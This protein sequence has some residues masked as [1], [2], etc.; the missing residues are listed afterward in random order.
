MVDPERFGNL[1]KP[2]EDLHKKRTPEQQRVLYDKFKHTNTSLL[3]EAIDHLA[4]TAKGFPTPGDIKQAI[5]EVSSKRAKEGRSSTQ[6]KGCPNCHNGVVF[7]EVPNRN[8][9]KIYAGSCAYCHKGEVTIVPF[10]VQLND[11]IFDACEMFMD[12]STKRYRANPDIQELYA[13]AEPCYSN[14]WLKG[15]SESK[16]MGA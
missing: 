9:G 3:E 14:A 12:G 15:Y 2:L 6:E 5:R 4:D 10:Q 13:E 11:Q 1:I 7:Y 8:N 16:R